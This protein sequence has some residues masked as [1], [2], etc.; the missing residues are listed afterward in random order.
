M[1][2]KP[3]KAFLLLNLEAEAGLRPTRRS[4]RKTLAAAEFV[5]MLTPF[6]SDAMRHYAHVLLPIGTFA[7]TSGTFV[8]AEGRWQSFL[9]VATPVGEARP[10]VEGAARAREPARPRGFRLRDLGR[11]AR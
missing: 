3:R 10:G 9:G 6:A 1:L 8:N 11:S 5:V 7:E 4:A 2:E